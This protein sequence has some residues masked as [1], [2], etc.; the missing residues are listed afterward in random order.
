MFPYDPP[1][2][3]PE[4]VG[5]RDRV[6]P[7]NRVYTAVRNMLA[8]LGLDSRNF[9][10][11]HWNPL[12][13]LIRRGER[14][15]IKPNWVLHGS[16]SDPSEFES[17][18]THSSVIRPLL[19]YL[20]LAMGGYGTIEVADAPLQNCDFREL[21]KRTRIADLLE[22]Y[23]RDFGDVEFSVI[24][25]RK[26][27]L[28]A[29]D[30]RYVRSRRQTQQSGD[31]RDY[32]L[33]DLGRSSLLTDIEHRYRRFRVANYD[34]RLM[35]PHHN[36]QRHEYLV[37]NSVLSADLLVNVPKLKC[38]V[39]AGITGALKNLVGINGHKEF[40]PH[41]TVGPPE[42]D[43]DQYP[44]YSRLLPVANQVY[45][46]Y[47]S[48]MQRLPRFLGSILSL[49]VSAL[50]RSSRVLEGS[51]TFDGGWL[52]NETIPRTT[53]DLNH[54]LY[55]YDPRTARLST[56][57]VRNVFHLVDGVIAGEGYGPLRPTPKRAGV[58]IGGW[59]PLL[60]DV[61]GARL[62]GLDPLR[63]MLLRCGLDRSRSRLAESVVGWFGSE[64]RYDGIRKAIGDIR[65][66][67]FS[68]PRGWEGARDDS[69]DAAVYSSERT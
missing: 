29:T 55:F 22:L 1:A 64:I 48:N 10:T 65:S 21:V 45:D 59:N 13:H 57:P 6:D 4:L 52:G 53:L 28:A 36:R 35:L 42:L 5:F 41:H 19:D 30:R 26:T 43:G 14:A 33:V 11:V 24:D 40:L 46:F 66:L 61:C 44:T 17:V 12:K 56:D 27:L 67:A 49:V 7:E 62:M 15:L 38:H 47:W 25:L 9:G 37:S 23:R 2:R 39:K 16:Q 20:I 54:V 34:R 51:F 50:V 60:V 63:V 58:L 69:R 68:L 18:V 31:P 8:D 3:F 32:T